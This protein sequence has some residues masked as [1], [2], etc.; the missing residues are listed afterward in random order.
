MLSLPELKRNP[1]KQG[2][3]Y[4]IS[5][6]EDEVLEFLEAHEVT[7][8]TNSNNF[9][10]VVMEMAHKEIIQNVAYISKVWFPDFVEGGTAPSKLDDLWENLRPTPTKVVAKL[11]SDPVMSALQQKVSHYLKKFIRSSPDKQPQTFPRFCR[12]SDPMV[13]E[14]IYVRFYVPDGAYVSTPTAH[15]CG[16]VLS[17]PEKYGSA[18]EL[19]EKFSNLFESQEI[20]VMD[21][22]LVT[23]VVIGA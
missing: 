22:M 11:H 21:F 16:A 19:Q 8:W 17:V 3:K 9:S 12:G 23:Y 6:N 15:T 4:F 20:W 13:V 5:V 1:V 14:K 10:K 18:M 7:T 2:L